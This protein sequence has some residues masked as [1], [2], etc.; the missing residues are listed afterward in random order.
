MFPR[1]L[2]FHTAD[3]VGV[4]GRVERPGVEDRV[5]NNQFVNLAQHGGIEDSLADV[6]FPRSTIGQIDTASINPS[7]IPGGRIEWHRDHTAKVLA[8][9][10][11]EDTQFLQLLADGLAKLGDSERNM[12]AQG[13]IG[14]ANHRPRLFRRNVRR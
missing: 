13:A 7:D 2:A 9:V 5:G 3:N 6:L 1:K 8:A 14:E 10:G 12:P 4:T 11:A